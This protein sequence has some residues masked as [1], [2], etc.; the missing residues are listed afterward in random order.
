[1]DSNSIQHFSRTQISLCLTVKSETSL[2]LGSGRCGYKI[3]SVLT[4][5][6]DCFGRITHL[7]CLSRLFLFFIFFVTRSLTKL[8]EGWPSL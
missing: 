1:M 4:L 6:S 7:I 2:S 8:A 5:N 3:D